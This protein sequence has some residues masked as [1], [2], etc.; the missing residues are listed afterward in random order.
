MATNNDQI[1]EIICCIF[2]PPLAIWWHTK[3]CGTPVL[4]DILLCFLFW[5][6][7]IIYAVWFCFFN[8]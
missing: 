3:D 2:L 7:A 6:P 4:I 5:I 1:I 8:E